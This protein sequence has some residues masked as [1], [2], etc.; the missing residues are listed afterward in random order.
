MADSSAKPRAG[1]ADYARAGSAEANAGGGAHGRAGRRFAPRLLPTLA[2]ALLVPLFVALGQWQWGKAAVKDDL[3]T[4]LDT[5]SA[6]APVQLAATPVDAAALRYRR[7]VVRGVWEPQRQ[8]LIDNRIYRERAGYHV[9]TPLRI[10]GGATRVLVNRGWI[11]ALPEHSRVPVVDTPAGPV[12]VSGLAIVPSARFF[13]L[14][15]DAGSAAGTG[16]Q[17][18]TVWQN[19]DLA[20]YRAVVEALEADGANGAEDFALQPVVVQMAPDSA[21]GGFAREWPRPDERI[22]RHLGYALQWWSFA[23]TTVLIWLFVNFRRP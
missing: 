13:T 9:L 8:I 3:Q 11:P 17:W 19:L 18:Q 4:L 6:E 1:Q 21:G 22:E 7:I 16:T 12:D 2:A 20:R 5:R 23:A 15:A 14:G 10:E